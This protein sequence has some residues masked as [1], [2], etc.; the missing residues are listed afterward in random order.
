MYNDD[1]LWRKDS[2]TQETDPTPQESY[3]Y[4][5]TE[6]D[7]FKYGELNKAI[8][9]AR[10]IALKSIVEFSFEEQQAI[11]VEKHSFGCGLVSWV[12]FTPLEMSLEIAKLAIEIREI[13][14][15]PYGLYSDEQ[16]K[17]N[18]L[19]KQLTKIIEG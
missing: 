3:F 1:Q 12:E 11:R 10:E 14:D 15:S 19:K 2:P 4:K 5:V 9:Q 17:L 7:T 6:G 13:Q 16:V 8:E 18:E